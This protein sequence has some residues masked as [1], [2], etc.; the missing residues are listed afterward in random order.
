[1][2]N[3]E[4][5]Q[6]FAEVYNEFWCRYK[7]RVPAK[8]SPEWER[9][10]TRYTILRKK[11]PFLGETL[12]NLA[13]ELDR[14]MRKLQKS[15]IGFMAGEQKRQDDHFRMVDGVFNDAYVFYKKFHGKP[16]EPGMTEEM[17][18]EFGSILKKYNGSVFCTRIMLAVFSQIEEETR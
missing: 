7:D 4:V 10:Y 14:R 9:I 5:R 1:M 2:T 12:S 6:G 18:K 17:T 8:H 16:L 15:G 3:E 13:A 11:Y